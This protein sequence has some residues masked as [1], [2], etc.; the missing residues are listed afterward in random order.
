[1]RWLEGSVNSVDVGLCKLGGGEGQGSLTR[2]GPWG[3]KESDTTE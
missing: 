1:M 3:R 2:C